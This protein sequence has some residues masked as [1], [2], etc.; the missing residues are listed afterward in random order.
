MKHAQVTVPI[1]STHQQDERA[2]SELQKA[3]LDVRQLSLIGKPYRPDRQLI[4]YYS[5][6]NLLATWG[7][8]RPFRVGLRGLFAGSAFFTLPGIG[9]LLIAGPFIASL[10]LLWRLS[11]GRLFTDI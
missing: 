9:P 11:K 5:T 6:A 3:G 8:V 4:G 2:V 7:N 10:R 1:Y